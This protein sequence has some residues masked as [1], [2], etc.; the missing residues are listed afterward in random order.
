MKVKTNM[1]AAATALLL[2]AGLC[3]SVE[4]IG[5]P[6]GTAFSYQG[7][8]T[9]GTNAANGFYDFQFAVYDRDDRH[10]FQWGP[11]LS[12]NAVP[13][14]NGLF[15]VQLDF[16]SDVFNGDARWLGIEVKTNG[17]ATYTRLA[18]RQPLLPVPYALYSAYAGDL[19]WGLPAGSVG[20][21]Q[22]ASGAVGN[23]ALAPSAVTS[24]NIADGTIISADI[25]PTGIDAGKIIGGDLQAQRL[26]VGMNHTLTGDYATIAGGTDNQASGM[27]AAVGGGFNNLSSGLQATVAGGHKN[28]AT[29]DVSVVA[30]GGNNLA[31]GQA[32]T[33]AG[34]SENRAL[35]DYA[36]VGGGR[37]HVAY[38]ECATVAGGYRNLA[39]N[40]CATV[41]GGLDNVAGASGATVAGGA[42]NVAGYSGATV[43][44][45]I[46]NVAT[47]DCAT[48][49]GGRSNLASGF[50][51]TVAGGYN[52]Q[53][54]GD[55]S[56]AAGQSAQARNMGSVVFADSQY[57]DFYSVREDEFAIRARNGV[58]LLSDVG[59]HLDALDGPLIVRDYDKFGDYAP[60]GKAGIG[61]WG[62]FME[63]LALT[64]G[65]PSANVGYPEV[66]YRSLQVARYDLDGTAHELFRVGNDGMTTVKALTITGGSDL[67]EP[68]EISDQDSAPK[69]AVVVIDDQH[70]GRLRVSDQPYDKRVA[71]V[72]SG[73][74]GLKPG[75]TMAQ[76]G[77]TDKGAAVALSGRVYT[78]AT[79]ANGAMKVTDSAKAQGAVLGKAMS[80]LK[81]GQGMVLVLV[82]LQ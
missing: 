11:T 69:G 21:D 13:V 46:Y 61:R 53:A 14:S 24:D 36:T 8:L 45:G 1:L 30:G 62:L 56:F 67:A 19:L 2:L 76:Q 38:G 52:N 68:F 32:A 6:M 55:F 79:A 50:S 44:G 35:S 59:I 47:H 72:V 17:A 82:S 41:A 39:T 63:P 43:A 9:S 4:P 49:A 12:T 78:L 66:G 81:E 27:R 70:P 22:L 10:G 37:M 42:Y 54:S 77:A 64:L 18:P 28:W 31:G 75:L 40:D 7:K 71:G 3:A 23:A 20:T 25:S 51:A 29:G 15:V 65:I 73:A 34:G 60:N 74:G 26:K 33:V 80:G 5:T 16:L 58:C 57:G 48:V